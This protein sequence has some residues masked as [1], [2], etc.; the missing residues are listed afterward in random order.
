MLLD[1]LARC[2]KEQPS[3]A[4]D[5]LVAHE[6]RLWHLDVLCGRERPQIGKGAANQTGASGYVR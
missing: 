1:D 3:F 5:H 4:L 6:W 2:R